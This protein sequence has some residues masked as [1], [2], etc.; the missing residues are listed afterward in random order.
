MYRE[1]SLCWVYKNQCKITR[2]MQGCEENQNAEGRGK[3]ARNKG[4]SRGTEKLLS[5]H[6]PKE[7]DCSRK[8]KALRVREC[9][10]AVQSYREVERVERVS[11]GKCTKAHRSLRRCTTWW[12]W[13]KQSGLWCRQ[14]CTWQCSNAGGDAV[15]LWRRGGIRRGRWR[16]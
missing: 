16:R 15:E 8:G 5:L 1:W 9:V 2:R 4:R 12:K 7:E 14:Q 10:V 11:W 13:R 3:K 6:S